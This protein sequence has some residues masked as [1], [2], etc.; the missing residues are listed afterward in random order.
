MLKAVALHGLGVI[1]INL[2]CDS[3][4]IKMLKQALALISS[5]QETELEAK[6]RY[7]TW[8]HTSEFEYAYVSLTRAVPLFDQLYQGT[9]A[10]FDYSTKR[11]LLLH[12][13]LYQTLI[14]VLVKQ[15]KVEEALSVAEK[16]SNS[17][18]LP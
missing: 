2:R 3:K 9:N 12:S 5:S 1:N 16:E 7:T 18:Y 8:V 15:N 14:H 17:G 13:K 11:I 10:Y 6:I 4:A